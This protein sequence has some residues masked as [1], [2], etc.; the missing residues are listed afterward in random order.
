MFLAVGNTS[1]H[2]RLVNKRKVL[3]KRAINAQK[4]CREVTAIIRN[5]MCAAEQSAG[6]ATYKM[7][8]WIDGATNDA[9]IGATST[10]VRQPREI[11]G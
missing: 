4:I 8:M 6:W 7:G 9:K 3:I 1:T 11:L 10:R 5:R 2:T